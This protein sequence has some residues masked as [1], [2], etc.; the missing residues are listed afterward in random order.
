MFTQSRDLILVPFPFY[1]RLDDL[2]SET[3]TATENAI[4][5]N[6]CLASDRVDMVFL[7]SGLDFDTTF[8]FNCFSSITFLDVITT[9]VLS[10]SNNS[11]SFFYNGSYQLSCSYA[12]ASIWAPFHSSM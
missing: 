11:T 8:G 2:T 4:T 5:K 9:T 6:G 3:R 12:V 10:S 1:L 7:L